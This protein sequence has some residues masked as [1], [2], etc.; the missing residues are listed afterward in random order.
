MKRLACVFLILLILM[1]FSA[2]GKTITQPNKI[3]IK[4]KN[5]TNFS[6]KSFSCDEYHA[7]VLKS[8][9]TVQNADD[10]LIK[11]GEEF[12]FEFESSNSDSLSFII[13]ATDESGST[14]Y[15]DE[16]SADVLS[17]GIIY[18][19]SARIFNNCLVLYFEGTEQ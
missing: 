16:F 4:V 12:I 17:K 5:Q 18:V 10:S 3:Y 11:N 7:S 14:F 9:T 8:S 2:C 19:Y 15:A 6:I 13:S 1:S